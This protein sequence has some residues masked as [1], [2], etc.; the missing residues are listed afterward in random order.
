MHCSGEDQAID[1]VMPI[2]EGMLIVEVNG[3]MP[4]CCFVHPSILVRLDARVAVEERR[5]SAA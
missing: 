1:G 2:V 4:L 3:G 5:F